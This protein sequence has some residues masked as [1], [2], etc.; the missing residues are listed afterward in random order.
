MCLHAGACPLLLFLEAHVNKPRLSLW[1][2]GKYV[3]H[4]QANS[5]P[6]SGYMSEALASPVHHTPPVS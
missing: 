5:Q 6:I 4:A 2:D 1:N 3:T